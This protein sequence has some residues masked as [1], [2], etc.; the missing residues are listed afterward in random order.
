MTKQELAT[1]LIE[2]NH[3]VDLM[4]D[5]TTK[6]AS[7]LGFDFDQFFDVSALR[8][9]MREKAIEIYAQEL[10]AEELTAAI[11]YAQ[12]PLGRS[13]LSKSSRI[14]ELLEAQTAQVFQDALRST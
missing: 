9:G 2:I 4:I 6:I 5:A 12:S 1:Q 7:N 14:G 10:T 3:S 8:A 13:I 11:D